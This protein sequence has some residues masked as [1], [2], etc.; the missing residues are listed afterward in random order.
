[1]DAS[2]QAGRVAVSLMGTVV[3]MLIVAT[4]FLMK[5]NSWAELEAS[6]TDADAL[7]SI[8]VAAGFAIISSFS[9][10][11]GINALASA[12]RGY[13]GDVAYPRRR[14]I[15]TKPHERTRAR[16]SPNSRLVERALSLPAS[17]FKMHIAQ[18]KT[19]WM[20]PAANP[21]RRT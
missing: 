21:V 18:G 19:G 5:T 15:I 11:A 8:P 3:W 6:L 12:N 13:R 16:G 20:C 1:V 17:P 9:A 7:V 10:R 4:Y 14:G 2:A